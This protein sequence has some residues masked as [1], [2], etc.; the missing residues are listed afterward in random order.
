MLRFKADVRIG[1]LD[2]RMVDVLRAAALWSA[3][4]R[5]ELEVNSFEDPA[6]G[7]VPDSFHVIGLAVDLDTVGD[8]PADTAALAEF[9]RQYLPAGYDVLFEGD[10]VHVEADAHR[11]PLRKST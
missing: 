1:Y 7:R 11:G 9:L 4:T 8:K 10:H 3:R 2:T 6:P 5:V